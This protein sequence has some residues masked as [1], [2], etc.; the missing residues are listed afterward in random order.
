[1]PDVKVGVQIP[2]QHATLAQLRAAW[3]RADAM[4]V[5]SLWT[6]DHFFPLSGD[7]DGLHYVGWTLLA[8]MA[9]ATER[10]TIG[11][12]VACNSY[13]NP[14]LVADMG[15]TIDHISG[16]RFILG[17]GSGWFERDY[18][19]YGY[20]FKDAPARLRDLAAALPVIAERLD[21]LNPGPVNGRL[22]IMIGGTGEKVTLRLAAQHADI[23]N[24]FGDPE[25]AG[26]L[27]R[28]LDDW[29]ARVGRDPATIERSILFGQVERVAL[30]DDYLRHG[31]THLI[32]EFASPPYDFAPVEQLLAWRDSIRFN[33]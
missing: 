33:E 10:P 13:R 20:D 26:R 3:R 22:P 25:E 15:R 17:I 21:E 18:D 30:A 24:G 12:L 32:F 9:E 8:A 23:W 2:P 29:C 27:S 11:P 6:W 1:M 5:D 16:G 19:D 7:P 14:N 4:G 28:V 31:I